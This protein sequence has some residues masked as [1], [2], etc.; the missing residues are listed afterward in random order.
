MELGYL[1]TNVFGDHISRFSLTESLTGKSFVCHLEYLG[2]ID[3]ILTHLGSIE[4]I[5]LANCK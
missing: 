5:L 4:F 2:P 1:Y 3:F